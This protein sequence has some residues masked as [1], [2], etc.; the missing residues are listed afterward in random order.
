MWVWTALWA[1][2]GLTAGL[3]IKTPIYREPDRTFLRLLGR[4]TLPNTLGL[5]PVIQSLV[6]GHIVHS[7][8][9]NR[10]NFQYFSNRNTSNFISCSFLWH[11][12]SSASLCFYIFDYHKCLR[13]IDTAS[14][15]Q[16]MTGQRRR[17]L[18]DVCCTKT[19]IKIYTNIID[20]VFV[21]CLDV[22]GW[23]YKYLFARVGLLHI[24]T[25]NHYTPF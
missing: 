14:Q 18:N 1:Q 16:C 12:Q 10:L 9:E 21:R 15:R 4:Y 7:E 24:C 11:T 3:V 13:S 20:Y 17:L 5:T 23:F 8:R 19:Y 25:P 6:R 2:C 22:Y